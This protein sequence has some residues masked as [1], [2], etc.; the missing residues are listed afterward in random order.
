[1][2]FAGIIVIALG[3]FMFLKPDLWV[4]II[5]PTFFVNNMG[6]SSRSAYQIMGLLGSIFGVLL[7]FGVFGR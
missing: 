4:E 3:I 2:F 1:M 6:M 5:P 7:A